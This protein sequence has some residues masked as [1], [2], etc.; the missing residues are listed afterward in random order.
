MFRNLFGEIRQ[1]MLEHRVRD[2]L[3]TKYEPPSRARKSSFRSI[4]IEA[5][6]VL[7]DRL[8]FLPSGRTKTI[9]KKSNKMI[10]EMA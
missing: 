5:A 4:E 7:R 1:Q 6:K 2:C 3:Q 8:L 10:C 9:S